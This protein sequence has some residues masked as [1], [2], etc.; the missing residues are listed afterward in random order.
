MNEDKNEKV[1]IVNCNCGCE[2]EIHIKR[3]DDDNEEYYL[4]IHESKFSSKQNGLWRTFKERIKSIWRIIRGKE[5][6]LCDIV[7]TK[8]E[9]NELVEKL[10]KIKDDNQK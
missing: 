5:Y 9:L 3:F 8:S 10:I 7:L 4:S 2:E 6:L 1:V